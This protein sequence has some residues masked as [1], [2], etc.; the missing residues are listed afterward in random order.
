M[1]KPVFALKAAACLLAA[2]GPAAF[3]Q[4]SV[5]VS[6]DG[7][8]VYPELDAFVEQ[9]NLATKNDLQGS[10]G[11]GGG[12]GAYPI[13]HISMDEVFSTRNGV[14]I[15]QK[16]VEVEL[17]VKDP[18]SGD[19]LYW[20]STLRD[21]NYM[22][23]GRRDT[24]AQ[25]WF[26]CPRNLLYWDNRDWIAHLPKVWE[27]MSDQLTDM[28]SGVHFSRL[29]DITDAAIEPNVNGFFANG[30]AV[31]SLWK[32]YNADLKPVFLRLSMAGKIGS[33]K[34][35]G[36]SW[37]NTKKEMPKYEYR[38]LSK[39]GD[40]HSEAFS[41]DYSFGPDG[42]VEFISA[43]QGEILF[44]SSQ[45]VFD[46]Y[47]T[48]IVAFTVEFPEFEGSA[49]LRAGML[50]RHTP[51]EEFTA[52]ESWCLQGIYP[53]GT[54]GFETI[55][56]PIWDP[57]PYPRPN[58]HMSTTRTEVNRKLQASGT[59]TFPSKTYS[60][61]TVRVSGFLKPYD[62]Q[63]KMEWKASDISATFGVRNFSYT[64][65]FGSPTYNIL[66]I[67]TSGMPKG[68]KISNIKI[69]TYH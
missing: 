42:T 19:A 17:K 39:A 29:D 12:A 35:A 66:G 28:T 21:K 57:G 54:T 45:K 11:S 68:A 47:G 23:Y 27:N 69:V 10:G 22:E 31:S 40:L 1:T 32:N 2:I 38:I 25:A 43:A 50:N 16:P 7:R 5:M 55:Y 58:A 36:V 3:G 30:E 14:V 46:Y 48:T 59:Y 15:S 67:F 6:K 60:G 49:H 51:S 56:A 41:G 52:T 13:V 20:F 63:S 8:I 18:D 24:D 65:Q 4:D 9:N 33:W 64:F 26:T 44:T 34:I 62:D 61:K 53:V 37:S